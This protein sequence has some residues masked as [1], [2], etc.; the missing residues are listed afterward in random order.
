MNRNRPLAY[1]RVLLKLSGEFLQGNK[2]GGIDPKVLHSIACEVRDAHKMGVQI[3]IVIGGGNIFRGIHSNSAEIDRTAADYMGMLATIINSLAFQNALEN[4]GAETRVQSAIEVSKIAEPFLVRKAVNHL[5]SG[6]IVIFAAGT[7][8]PYFST[9]TAAVLRAL[10]IQADVILKGTKVDGVYD[11]DPVKHS[12][13]KYYKY[14]SYIDIISKNLKVMDLTAITLCRENKMPIIVFN[15]KK[16][17]NIRNVI[18]GMPI[19]TVVGA[20]K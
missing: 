1:Q 12:N 2:K 15:L 8:S 13:A 17:G 14:I 18:C 4:I 16:K 7:G 19:G 5:E 6:R 10:E 11:R 9:D 20:D 3:G